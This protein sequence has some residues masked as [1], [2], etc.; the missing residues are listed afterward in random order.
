VGK[1]KNLVSCFYFEKDNFKTQCFIFMFKISNQKTMIC[2]CFFYGLFTYCPR[3][4]ALN[5]AFILYASKYQKLNR[6]IIKTLNYI[7]IAIFFYVF[8]EAIP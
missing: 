7:F 2:N 4:A 5:F 3:I 6:Q 8:F 1:E